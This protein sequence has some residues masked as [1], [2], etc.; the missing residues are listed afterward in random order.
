MRHSFR[1]ACVLLLLGC[2]R[3][4]GAQNAPIVSIRPFGEIAVE[5]FTANETFT[6]VFG[7][8][9]GMFYGG[10]VQVTFSDR[11]YAELSLSRF[12]RSGE[13]VYRDPTTGRVF[14]LNIPLQ[15]TLTPL[16]VTGGYRFHT[17]RYRWLVPYAGGGVG[18][19][20]YQE[21]CTAALAVCTAVGPDLDVTRAGFVGHGGV[22]LRV[23][24]D[25]GIAAEVQY[26]HVSGIFGNSGISA[27]ANEKDL[28]GIAGRIKIVI[29]R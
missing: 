7:D 2:A 14:D 20:G 15:A 22:E 13:Q 25:V 11:V 18:R 4:G 10:G 9:I 27:D 8:S 23:H 1:A 24:K 16:E 6:S 21:R 26:T 28:G 5:R 3:V 29:G 19:F 17:R 12:R